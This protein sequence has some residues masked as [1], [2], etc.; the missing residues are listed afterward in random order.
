MF[1]GALYLDLRGAGF[2]FEGPSS[3]TASQITA[4][5]RKAAPHAAQSEASKIH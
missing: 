4:E 3:V 1:R 5:G 2:K